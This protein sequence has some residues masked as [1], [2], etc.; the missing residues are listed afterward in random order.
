MALQFF[1]TPAYYQAALMD[2]SDNFMG[3]VIVMTTTPMINDDN[4]HAAL[5][6]LVGLTNDEEGMVPG[7][8]TH[9]SIIRRR[10]EQA[11]ITPP[12]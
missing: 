8:V 2:E 12:A 7:P 9:L 6:G 4:I 10:E 5:S 1:D 11:S 3:S